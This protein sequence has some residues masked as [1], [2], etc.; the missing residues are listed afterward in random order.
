[1]MRWTPRKV[2]N[3]SPTPAP[4]AT[5]IYLVDSTHIIS[6]RTTLSSPSIRQMCRLSSIW[7]E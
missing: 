7:I 5:S 2:K 4:E 3:F 6:A 1:M